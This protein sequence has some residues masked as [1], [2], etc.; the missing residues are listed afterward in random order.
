MRK[1]QTK[2]DKQRAHNILTAAFAKDSVTNYILP[3]ESGKSAFF[4]IIV[5]Y[6]TKQTYLLEDKAA[7]VWFKKGE[8]NKSSIWQYF[9]S[10]I[11]SLKTF[12]EFGKRGKYFSEVSVKFYALTRQIFLR[13]IEFQY[14]S[15]VL[16]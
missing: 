7:A 15:L 3:S 2:E 11:S 16:Q 14:F 4:N 6:F 9:K 10:P 13:W 5:N 8:A 12:L 1:I